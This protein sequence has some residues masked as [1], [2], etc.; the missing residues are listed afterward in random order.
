MTRSSHRS[1][2]RLL[3]LGA[4]LLGVVLQAGTVRAQ[5]PQR[6]NV[7]PTAEVRQLVTFLFAPGRAE[8]ARLIYEKSLRPLYSAQTQLLRFRAYHETESPE[9]LDLIVVSSYAGMAGMDAAS[10]GLRRPGADGI[11][12]LQWY[13]TL[14]AMTQSHHDEFVLMLPGLGD[15]RAAAADTTASLTVFEY[16]R[17]TPGSQAAFER[18]LETRLRPFEQANTPLRWS[19]TGRLLVGDGWD[20]V[21]SFGVRSLADWQ[22]YRIALWQ[23]S[24]WPALGPLIVAQK[25]IIVR[26]DPRLGVR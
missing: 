22:A 20:Y 23:G 16:V 10:S 9:P 13:G 12:A 25:T 17:V 7:P 18:L 8:E 21:R 4:L 2:A 15:S 11:T 3:S 26:N 5:D 1:T 14:S 24:I 6:A 19:E